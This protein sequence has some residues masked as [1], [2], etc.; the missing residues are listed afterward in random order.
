MMI[1]IDTQLRP[2]DPL[3]DALDTPARPKDGFTSILSSSLST[4][5]AEAAMAVP[6]PANHG[7]D[8]EPGPEGDPSYSAGE[9]S[10]GPGPKPA[11]PAQAT[12]AGIVPASGFMIPAG[13]EVE[14]PPA[15]RR[16]MQS[17]R[18][19]EDALV[20]APSTAA[21]A[22]RIGEAGHLTKGTVAPLAP[23][24][25]APAVQPE[26]GSHPAPH[27][28]V[29]PLPAPR[30]YVSIP[31]RMGA[32]HLV[33][34]RLDALAAPDAP[35]MQPVPATIPTDGMQ[36]SCA[37]GPARLGTM[38]N[39]S[40]PPASEQG[41]GSRGAPLSCIS[42]TSALAVSL[43]ARDGESAAMLE[44]AK[45]AASWVVARSI[46]CDG[47][48]AAVQI[49]RTGDAL[50]LSETPASGTRPGEIATE[51]AVAGEPGR[52]PSPMKTEV[53]AAGDNDPEI[54][55]ELPEPELHEARLRQL[56]MAAHLEGTSRRIDPPGPSPEAD[57]EDLPPLGDNLQKSQGLRPRESGVQSGE[58]R[59]ENRT[60]GI[61][62]QE[63]PAQRVMIATPTTR[64]K[65][66]D[67]DSSSPATAAVSR[68][69]PT[70]TP[71][72]IQ[73]AGE[74]SSLPQTIAA[75]AAARVPPSLSDADLALHLAERIR[76]QISGDGD[77]I[78]IQLKPELLGRIEIKA[79]STGDGL[80]AKI[81]TESGAVK[82]YLESHLFILRESLAE[83]GF[84]IDRIDVQIQAD[85]GQRS[86]HFPDQGSGSGTPKGHG[87]PDSAGEAPAAPGISS[88]T[89]VLDPATF[90]Y[91]RPDVT[92]YTIA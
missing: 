79:E 45:S 37:P 30:A 51:P 11:E 41:E 65:G 75:Q 17:G 43:D 54:R 13:A 77:R 34:A 92:F 74:G 19:E 58:N 53:R 52:A 71:A 22:T 57:G 28:G 68:Q 48:E 62:Q 5:A 47:R 88:E 39:L 82:Q 87:A 86:S 76:S 70:A 90:L 42:R 60:S 8:S 73:N 91:L 61:S 1:R 18:A 26:P 46:L 27:Q 35:D 4:L 24:N 56:P 40:P 16:P 38:E 49:G 81:F 9:F 80:S 12:P 66:P 83:S 63:Q 31:E 2:A 25:R 23:R 33:P 67:A 15:E 89:L 85:L 69:N 3:P 10:V 59:G 6:L 55:Y 7:D 72:Q 50:V 64:W 29:L 32:A 21:V 14:A 20:T 44:P 36:S 78:Y 84:R